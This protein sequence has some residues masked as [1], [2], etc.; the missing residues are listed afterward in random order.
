MTTTV[1]AAEVWHCE[2]MASV[3][4]QISW[5]PV[6]EALDHAARSGQAGRSLRVLDLGGGA[7][8]DA[9]RVAQRHHAVTVVDQNSDALAALHLRAREAAVDI[10]GIQGDGESLDPE[11]FD[12]AFDLALCHGV[13]ETSPQPSDVFAALARVLRPGGVVSIQVPGLLAAVK[14]AVALGDVAHAAELTTASLD[15][16]NV[17]A[18]G[19]RR[20]LWDDLS[21]LLS[22]AGFTVIAIRGVRVFGDSTPTEISQDDAQR[23]EALL[24]LEERL[25]SQ[26][27]FASGSGG[28]QA[29]GRLD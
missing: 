21:P 6:A 22:A 8:V 26:R 18:L 17:D 20:Y 2:D 14:H 29:I 13:L 11:M 5:L 25:S 12:D 23:F 7:G 24:E 27:E 4:S 3:R 16:W 15:D 19:P 9:V 10:A 1:Y 28:L